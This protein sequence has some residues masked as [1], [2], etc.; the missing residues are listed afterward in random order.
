MICCRFEFCFVFVLR[1]CFEHFCCCFFCLTW[2]HSQKISYST[3]VRLHYVFCLFTNR[4][5]VSQNNYFL[6][7]HMNL[8]TNHFSTSSHN[9]HSFASWHYKTKP[10]ELRNT[11]K[12]AQWWRFFFLYK[13]LV[14]QYYG[15][16]KKC[17]GK[18]ID[19]GR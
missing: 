9:N 2:T 13:F 7:I 15:I 11:F 19:K 16:C 18:Y 14:Y 10:L 17:C 4:F 5:F 1:F 3:N 8:F 6:I 12:R